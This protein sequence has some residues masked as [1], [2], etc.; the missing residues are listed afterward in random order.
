MAYNKATYNTVGV[1]W[2]RD[3]LRAE[4]QATYVD[5][6]IRTH[7]SLQSI[8]DTLRFYLLKTRVKPTSTATTRKGSDTRLCG[9]THRNL[10]YSLHIYTMLIC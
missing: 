1:W 6:R 10:R 2:W 9:V 8:G 3:A 4:P 5:P 7:P